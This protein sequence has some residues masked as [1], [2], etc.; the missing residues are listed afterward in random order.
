M[1][2]FPQIRESFFVEL[3][4]P[5]LT[6]NNSEAE[7]AQYYLD[8]KSPIYAAPLFARQNIEIPRPREQIINGVGGDIR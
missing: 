4:T 1:T 7:Y 2:V 5:M 6:F 8:F 3:H